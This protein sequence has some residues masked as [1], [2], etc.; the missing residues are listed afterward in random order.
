MLGSGRGAGEEGI[1]DQ[2]VGRESVDGVGQVRGLERCRPE[3]EQ[4]T[5]LAD[6]GQRVAHLPVADEGTFG[7]TRSWPAVLAATG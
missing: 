3:E 5:H 2:D 6:L 7:V 4:L 1:D